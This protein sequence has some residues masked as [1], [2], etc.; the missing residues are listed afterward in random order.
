MLVHRPRR[1][2]NIK[3]ILSWF[4]VFSGIWSSSYISLM[5][6]KRQTGKIYPTENLL[7]D[8]WLPC[9]RP[10]FEPHSS[11]AIFHNMNHPPRWRR[12]R[13]LHQILLIETLLSFQQTPDFE[14]MLGWWMLSVVNVDV[15]LAQHWVNVSWLMRLRFYFLFSN[16]TIKV[17]FHQ[18]T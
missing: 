15:A 6:C 12:S 13:K 8:P 10:G 14:S 16:R 17:L 11:C 3:P 9:M 1:W 7:V 5:L 2:P 18:L 4:P